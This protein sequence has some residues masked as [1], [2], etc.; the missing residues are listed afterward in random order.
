MVTTISFQRHPNKEWFKASSREDPLGDT[1]AENATTR[2]IEERGKRNFSILIHSLLG[3]FLGK[4]AGS[5]K[6]HAAAMAP[7]LEMEALDIHLETANEKLRPE[8]ELG[9]DLLDKPGLGDGVGCNPGLIPFSLL[10]SDEAWN[11][12][13]GFFDEEVNTHLWEKQGI[14]LNGFLLHCNVKST[15]RNRILNIVSRIVDVDSRVRRRRQ[16]SISQALDNIFFIRFL[17]VAKNVSNLHCA[18]L[19]QIEDIDSLVPRRRRGHKAVQWHK[20][21]RGRRCGFVAGLE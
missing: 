20:T 7:I 18:S 2:I 9:A 4:N 17:I 16:T 19:A 14:G 3:S 6:K 10:T 8:A 15:N 11:D 1:L 5:Q 12:G 21:H 13:I